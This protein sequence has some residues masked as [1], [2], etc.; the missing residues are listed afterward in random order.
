MFNTFA[1]CLCLLW[2]SIVHADSSVENMKIVRDISLDSFK[3]QGGAKFNVV[4]GLT[5]LTFYVWETDPQPI[6]MLAN[7]H[8]DWYSKSSSEAAI[9]QVMR[10]VYINNPDGGVVIDMGI[11]DGYIAALAASYGLPVIAVDAQPECVRRFR[12]AAVVNGWKDVR[13]YNNIMMD[14]EVSLEIPNGVCTGGSRFQNGVQ[15]LGDRGVKSEIVNSTTVH[16]AKIDDIVGDEKVLM[17]HLDVE[18]AELSVLRS[19]KKMLADNR[20][21]HIIFEFG[22]HRWK[23]THAA[24]RAEV[25]ATFQDM[26]CRIMPSSRLVKNWEKL[27]DASAHAGRIMDIWCTAP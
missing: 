10:D 15:L 1:V 3:A 4:P 27:Y 16:S 5:D 8:M 22:P 26:E 25:S 7:S 21:K 13:I 17:F 19:A 12:L 14:K 6:L 20:L 11:N 18:G 9:I 23:D 24:S 2:R